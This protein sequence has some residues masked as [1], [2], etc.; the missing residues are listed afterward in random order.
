MERQI[1]KKHQE[2]WDFLLLV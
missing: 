1:N 2:L